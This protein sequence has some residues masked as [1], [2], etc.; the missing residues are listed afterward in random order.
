MFKYFLN[1]ES[2]PDLSER[3]Y[4]ATV[5]IFFS[6]EI[7]EI[8]HCVYCFDVLIDYFDKNHFPGRELIRKDYNDTSHMP[9]NRSFLNNDILFP[10]FVTWNIISSSGHKSLRGCIGTFKPQPLKHGLRYYALTSALNDTRF[11]PISE[12]EFILF[13]V[14]LLTNF[15][16]IE[17]PLDWIIG[18]HGLQI[19]FFYKN[20]YMSAT[21]LPCVAKEQNWSKEETLNNLFVKAGMNGDVFDWKNLNMKVIRYQGSKAECTYDEYMK[22]IS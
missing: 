13:G 19:S 12:Q 5:R 22:I 18:I 4:L 11:P 15:E 16:I 1:G 7:A 2:N 8:S 6:F 21:Y 3:I 20:K 14:T 10:L 9:T 17:D